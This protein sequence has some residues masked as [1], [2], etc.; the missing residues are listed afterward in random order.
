VVA[1]QEAVASRLQRTIELELIVVPVIRLDPL[2]PPTFTPTS[3]L[4]PSSTPTQSPTPTQTQI[5]ASATPTITPTPTDTATPTQTS[6]P[7]P[8][9]A[10]IA[11]TGGNGVFLRDVPAGRVTNSL[12]EGAPVLILYRRETLND[13][14]WIEIQD[15]LGRTG[16][17]LDQFLAIR[18]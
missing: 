7:T 17:V 15:L 12:P 13:L 14:E 11:N 5:P 4:G 2:I 16:W 8:V 18:P 3:T 1:L 6:T 9:L 10:Y